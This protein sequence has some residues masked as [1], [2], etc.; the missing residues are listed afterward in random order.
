MGNLQDIF[1]NAVRKQKMGITVYLTSGLPIQGNVAGFDN[2][3]VI[4]YSKSGQT[5]IYKH[6]I[7]SI[8]PSEKVILHTPDAEEK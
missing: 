3:T 1:L 7:A 6:A 4:I 2:F 5:L 8:V